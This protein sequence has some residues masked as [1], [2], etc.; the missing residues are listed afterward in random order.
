MPSCK[1]SAMVKAVAWLYLI[2]VA[3]LPIARPLNIRY[4]GLVIPITD[5][6]FLIV[7]AGWLIALVSGRARIRWSWFYLP[8]ALYLGA[9]MLS[10]LTSDHLRFSAVKFLGK[11]YLVGLAVLTFNLVTSTPFVKR[12]AAAWLTGTVI[13]VV[14]SLL[15][16][17]LFFLGLRNLAINFVL[18]NYGSLP[19]GNYPRIEGLFEYPAMF[20]N[21]LGVSFMLVLLMWSTGCLSSRWAW[22]WGVAIS[23]VAAF[24]LTPGLGG[25]ALAFGI[26]LWL[27]FK[28]R[29]RPYLGRAA[30]TLGIGL[31]LAAFV[32]AA[33]ALFSYNPAGIEAPLLHFQIRPSHRALAWRS[34]FA[35]FSRHPILGRGVGLPV[36]FVSHVNPSGV[37]ETL[38]DAHNTVLS[39]MGES[40]LVGLLTFGSIIFFLLRGLSPLRLRGSLNLIIISYLVL[41]LIDSFFY[42]SLVGSFEDSRHLWVLF[43]ML[44]AAKAGLSES[45]VTVKAA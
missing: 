12:T 3:T 18:H 37:R 15:G 45:D 6:V 23:I 11:I 19:P 20:C 36:A 39:V 9:L 22:V 8:L 29:G 31:G 5:F 43:G 24:T 34:A 13:T 27:E 44:A 7:G 14:C 16:I 30:L 10:T 40:G 17:L 21:Y 42:Q 2:L 4:S 28:D 38:T 32:A 1:N 26:W 41:A 25:F 33:L 35:T